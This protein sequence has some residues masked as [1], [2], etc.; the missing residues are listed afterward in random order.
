MYVHC[1]CTRVLMQKCEMILMHSVCIILK[2][3]LHRMRCVALSCVA[4]S[5]RRASCCVT[6]AV[7]YR[8][9]PQHAA[10]NS[11]RFQDARQRKRTRGPHVIVTH[12]SATYLCKQNLQGHAFCFNSKISATG[13]V[14]ASKRLTYL[15]NSWFRW[16][17][18][19]SHRCRRYMCRDN[20]CFHVNTVLQP[21]RISTF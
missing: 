17:R 15:S 3:H 13:D 14:C 19:G 12:R 11:A 1:L 4:V 5:R 16:N 20:S 2:V 7:A 8:S 18:P 21:F 9:I 10:Y 6:F